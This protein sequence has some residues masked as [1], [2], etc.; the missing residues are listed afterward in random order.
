MV[1]HFF[2]DLVWMFRAAKNETGWIVSRCL[3]AEAALALRTAKRLRR[4]VPDGRTT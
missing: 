3:M 2:A 4:P 1:A